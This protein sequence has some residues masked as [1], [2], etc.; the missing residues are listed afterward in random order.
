MKNNVYPCKPQFYY[1][2]VGFKG[3]ST[4]YRHVFVMITNVKIKIIINI[5]KFKPMKKT[6]L[7]NPFIPALLKW[8]PILCPC[9]CNFIYGVCGVFICSSSLLRLVRREGYA[10]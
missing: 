2:K 9:I 4:L 3:G 8:T 5:N 7:F 1:I 6:P 10:S